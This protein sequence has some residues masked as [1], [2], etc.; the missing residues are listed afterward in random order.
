MTPIKLTSI[1]NSSGSAEK[2]EKEEMECEMESIGGFL[3]LEMQEG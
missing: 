1:L 2:K 3:G